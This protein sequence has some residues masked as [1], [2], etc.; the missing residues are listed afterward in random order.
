MKSQAD[1]VQALLGTTGEQVHSA[2]QAFQQGGLRRE[3]RKFR[4]LAPGATL[5]GALLTLGHPVPQ[6][7]PTRELPGQM[8]VA[9]T[10]RRLLFYTQGGTGIAKAKKLVHEVDRADVVGLE[11]PDL[12]EGV[13]KVLRA[14]VLTRDGTVLRFE[15]GRVAIAE[16]TRML[17]ELGRDL[18]NT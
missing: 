6:D 8:V 18:R 15:F 16:G 17:E 11:Q 4:S 13:L 9:L 2:A 3:L 14:G 7:A 10:D 1:H 12:V 5:I